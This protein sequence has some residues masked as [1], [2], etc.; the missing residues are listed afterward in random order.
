MV[1]IIAKVLE[2]QFLISCSIILKPIICFMTIKGLIVAA[3]LPIKCFYTLMIRVSA[4]DQGLVCSAFLDLRKVF[5]SLDHLILV[6]HLV[7][8]G[9]CDM[10]L[11]WL[12]NCLIDRTVDGSRTTTK[13][14][15]NY[16]TVDGSEREIMAK[17]NFFAGLLKCSWKWEYK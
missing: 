2:S 1:P 3:Y 6:K 15:S 12:C 16:C 8:L 17:N 4:L 5:D 14:T 7:Q 10:E 11:T 13:N 9:M